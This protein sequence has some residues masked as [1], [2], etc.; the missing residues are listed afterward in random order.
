VIPSEVY[1]V[2]YRTTGHG[3]SAATG[4]LGAG[5]GTL[6]LIPYLKT[7]YGL[8]TTLDVLAIISIVGAAVTLLLREPAGRTLEEASMEELV[9]GEAEIPAPLSV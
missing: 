2:R 1:P 5:I 3:I 6:L 8:A 9:Q 4:K 7:T